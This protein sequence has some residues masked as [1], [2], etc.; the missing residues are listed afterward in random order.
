MYE[1]KNLGS[2]MN[3][4]R[5]V[6]AAVKKL[7]MEGKKIGIL[8]VVYGR[9]LVAKP[10]TP[11]RTP[12]RN[13]GLIAGLIKGKQWIFISPDHK[14]SYFW[15]IQ[16]SEGGRLTSHDV[17]GDWGIHIF[18]VFHRGHSMGPI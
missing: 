3:L 7:A 12:L 8:C 6:F 9:V 5:I 18:S 17:L 14:D 15:G 2:R 16:N 1:N 11:Q 4:L 13:K 10:T